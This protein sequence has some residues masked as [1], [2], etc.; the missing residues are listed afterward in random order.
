MSGEGKEDENPKENVITSRYAC[1]GIVYAAHGT[2]HGSV[3][4]FRMFVC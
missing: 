4:Y 3:T 2:V 1:G